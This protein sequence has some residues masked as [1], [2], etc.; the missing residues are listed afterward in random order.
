MTGSFKTIPATELYW[1]VLTPAAMPRGAGMR[2]GVQV[3]SRTG[4]LDEMFAE[5]LPLSID[6]VKT[7]YTPIDSSRVLA[8]AVARDR[9]TTSVEPSDT[10]ATPAGIPAG[11]LDGQ[12]STDLV[13]GLNFL[14]GDLEPRPVLRAKRRATT[15]AAAVIVLLTAAT[16]VGLERRTFGLRARTAEHRQ[17]ASGLLANL[18]H[19]PTS[20]AG[21]TALDQELSRLTRT[22]APRSMATADAADA[23]QALLIAWPR[24]QPNADSAHKLR[25]ESLTATADNLALTVALEDRAEASPLSDALRRVAGWKLTQPTFTAN[26]TPPSS[27]A[28]TGDGDHRKAGGMLSLR[29]AADPTT[30]KA[31][32][33]SESGGD[34]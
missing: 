26:A 15:T 8:A 22:R 23:L 16:L 17:Q 30:P 31:S 28:G 21:L 32:P 20:D 6:A 7:A 19:K 9:L 12:G 14:W 34:K 11:L 2:P 29:L 5:F 25:T 3:L 24:P 33:R 10:A 1:A 4:E 13:R 27:T 18:Y